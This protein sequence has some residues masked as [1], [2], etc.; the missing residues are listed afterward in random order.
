[1]LL[2]RGVLYEG[3]QRGFEREM[4]FR[5]RSIRAY[6]VSKTFKETQA[7]REVSFSMHRCEGCRVGSGRAG[8][9]WVGP[10]DF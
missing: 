8:L 2:F 7:L 10:D 1:M 9:G 4:S 5:E 3:D 6:K